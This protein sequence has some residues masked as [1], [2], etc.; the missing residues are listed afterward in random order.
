MKRLYL[1]FAFVILLGAMLTDAKNVK[2]STNLPEATMIIL[3]TEYE[4]KRISWEEDGTLTVNI[5]NTS[6]GITVAINTG[7]ILTGYSINGE[8]VDSNTMS[9]IFLT[10]E[11]L[12]ED[13]EVY[14]NAKVKEKKYVVINGDPSILVVKYMFHD[15]SPSEWEDGRLVLTLDDPYQNVSLMARS[16]YSISSIRFNGDE[17]IESLVKTF[18]ISPG[19]VPD[20]ESVFDVTCVNLSE[21]RTSEFKVNVEGNPNEVEVTLAGDR[22]VIYT[23][24]DLSQPIKFNPE[25]DLPV[26][27]SHPRYGTVFYKVTINDEELPVEDYVYY[28]FDVKNGETIDVQVD[29]PD[30]QIPIRI[31]YINPGTDNAIKAVFDT[32]NNIVDPSVWKAEDWS[33]SMGTYVNIEYNIKDFIV[34]ATLNG[35]ETYD[36]HVSFVATDEAG[37]DLDI[38]AEAREPFNVTFSYALPAHFKVQV[39]SYGGEFVE[40]DDS[41]DRTVVT[42]PRNRSRVRIVPDEGWAVAYVYVGSTEVNRLDVEISEDCVVSVYMEEYPRDLQGV[43]YLDP[44]TDWTHRTLSLSVDSPFH[45]KTLDL[46]PGYNVFNYNEDDLPMVFE[47]SVNDDYYYPAF[48]NG[49]QLPTPVGALSVFEPGSVLRLYG[50][51]PEFFSTGC[52]ISEDASVKVYKDI[53]EELEA[54]SF[55][56]TVMSGTRFDIVPEKVNEVVVKVNGVEQTLQDDRY[57]ISIDSDSEITVEKGIPSG[58]SEFIGDED[59]VDVYSLQGIRVL[60]GVDP[61]QIKDLPAGIYIISGKKTVVR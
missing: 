3:E 61:S 29:Y 7:Y 48:L 8:Q 30:I 53:L 25:F 46:E 13:G 14:L 56:E 6:K 50:E 39:G 57:V 36:T 11:E 37:Y 33:V 12:P 21:S 22:L 38:T 40:M 49:E 41:K 20:G 42:V 24:D 47:V 4:T 51:Y 10:Y 44:T 31:H 60:R 27:I 1:L 18:E 17:A 32:N 34:S 15:Y 28:A 23:G 9:P 45:A 5:P 43:I 59:K 2:F 26:T 52:D 54:I 55:E 58:V 35:V 19:S 16:G